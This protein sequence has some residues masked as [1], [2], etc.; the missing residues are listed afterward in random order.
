M[1]F[2]VVRVCVT[3]LQPIMLAHA[4][5]FSRRLFEVPVLMGYRDRPL[6]PEEI[7]LRELCGYRPS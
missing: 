1:K 6:G 7:V 5:R 3:N 4:P 2:P